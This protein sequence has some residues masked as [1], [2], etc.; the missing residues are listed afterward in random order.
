MSRIAYID[1]Q[2]APIAAPLVHL[3]DR[4]YQFSDGVYEVCLVIEDELWDADGHFARLQRSLDAL[5]I[6]FEVNR[7]ALE[8]VM[9]EVLRRNRLRNALVYLQI[10]RGVAPRNHHFPAADIAPVLAIT[11]KPYSLANSERLAEKGVQVITAPDIRWGRVD[12]KS[13]S[14]LP[15]ALAK[16]AAKKAGAY[17]AILVRE[18]I[19]TEGSS[20]NVWIVDENNALVTHPTGHEILGGITRQSV[21]KA[22]EALGLHIEERAFTLED[23]KR[24][25]EA[26]VTSATS[27]VMPIVAIDDHKIGTGAPGATALS[28]RRGYMSVARPQ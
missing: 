25:P 10:T 16:Q 24:A 12:I 22:A 2:Y 20:T 23:A 26:F 9:R 7:R 21:M 13:I 3:E 6:V 14:L 17:E 5:E 4:G 11:V 15:N 18:G 1:G 28:L 19:V 8:I 27:Q